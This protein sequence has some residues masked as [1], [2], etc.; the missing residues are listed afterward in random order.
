MA[1]VNKEDFGKQRE[2]L[3]VEDLEDGADAIV[4]TIAGFEIVPFEDRKAPLLRFEES[5]DKAYFPNQTS[6]SHL[7]EVYGDETDDW[8]GKPLPLV[9]HKGT[10]QG[11]KFENLQVAAP[12][13]WPQLFKDA[14]VPVPRAMAA[15]QARVG[16]LAKAGKQAT[17]SAKVRGR[18]RK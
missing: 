3:K 1:R 6:M 18:G 12:E 15:K 14:E 5:G 17:K 13:L 7:I 8:M 4:L 16:I 11:K 2:K 10:F 9:R